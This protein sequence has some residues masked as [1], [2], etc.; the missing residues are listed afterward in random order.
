MKMKETLHYT[1]AGAVLVVLVS[2]LLFTACD[3]F[4]GD[5]LDRSAR[6]A[7]SEDVLAG[8]E[9][10]IDA[11]LTG[12]YAALDGVDDRPFTPSAL[13]GGLPWASSPD[14]WIYGTVAGG[15]AHKGST[16]GDQAPILTIAQMQHEPTLGFFDEKWKAGFE[17]I[18]R[19]NSVL[20]LLPQVEDLSDQER[21]RIEAEARFLRGHFYFDLKKNFGNVPWVADTTQTFKQPNTQDIWPNI[22]ADFEFAMNNL[23]E[24]QADIGRANRW[25]AMAYL[26]K[27]HLY[28]EDWQQARDLFVQVI[29]Q[30]VTSDG[31]PYALTPKY[32]DN[33]NPATENNSGTVFSIQQ[34][35]P[36][37][38]GGIGNSRGGNILNYPH[39]PS[40]F[41]CCGFY[42]PTLWLVNAFRTGPDG[43]PTLDP[44]QGENVKHDQGVA[45]NASF[46]LG[47]QVLD[48]R[49]EWTVGRRGVPFHDWGPHPGQLWI[50]EQATGGPFSPK[51]HIYRR[52]ER[53]TFGNSNA[54]APGSA[55]NYH[56]IRF[57]D[58]LLMAAEAEAELGNL[59][60]AR[61]YV[62]RVRERAANPDGRVTN[63]MNREFALAVVDNEA[64]MLATDASVGDWV[65]R[66]D[67]N[68]TFVLIKGEPGNI[69][70][71]NE[72][73]LPDYSVDPY[74]SSAFSSQQ[75]A[76]DRIRFERKLELAM[77]GHRFYD[78]V[79]WGIA[80]QRLDAYYSFETNNL[81]TDVR[82]GD[83][84]PN[85]NEY[86]PIP[87]RQIDLSTSGGEATL[88]QN[89]G[90]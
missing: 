19:A 27:T 40:P 67:R 87:Q 68:S 47:D 12:A 89:P 75:A 15:M 10:G 8:K 45:S 13:G 3:M 85:R 20:S 62:N 76:L 6:G 4:N 73:Q 2:G 29:D 43:L 22:E 88:Q 72:Y 42:Q 82:G 83:F 65:V 54:W 77:E 39:S 36:D 49:L 17:G 56:V 84:T 18:T 81:T 52:S 71:W 50:R 26:A 7:V 61:Q 58:V 74:P 31:Q 90:Y 46:A 1:T 34:T 37:G 86:Y 70:N 30:G 57:A 79:R 66:T 25:A 28:Q 44:A 69:D 59:E 60:P 41:R 63:A 48:P 9:G 53:N 5:F 14:N 32:Q 35:G 21:A 78:L 64:D 24:E 11:L 38:S 55:V 51:K 16:Q 80:D 33:F 23:P